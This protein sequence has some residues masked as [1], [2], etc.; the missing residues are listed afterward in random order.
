[1]DQQNRMESPEVNPHIHNQ[2]IFDKGGQNIQWRKDHLFRKWYQESWTTVYK[3]MKLDYT[4]TLY[5]KI[6]TKWLKD[7]NIRYDTMNI[8]EENLGKTFSDLNQ[9]NVSLGQSTKSI[10]IKAKIN[11]WDLI[12]LISLCTAKEIINK[13]KRQLMEWEKYL[14]MMRPARAQFPK[15]TNYSCNSKEK[16]KSKQTTHSKNMQKS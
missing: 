11:K 4:L 14:K 7:L 5:G 6:N 15:Y 1:M 12:K 3:S 13:M 10:E 9:R 2:L 16:A 8:L